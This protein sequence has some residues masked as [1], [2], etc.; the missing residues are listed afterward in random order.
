MIQNKFYESLKKQ[1]MNAV[2]DMNDKRGMLK[3]KAPIIT[4][5]GEY[6][7]SKRVLSDSEIKKNLAMAVPMIVAQNTAKPAAMA[8]TVLYTNNKIKKNKAINNFIREY[9]EEH[10]N[11]KLTDKEIMDLYE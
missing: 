11:T 3:A 8:F 4:F 9:K 5:D 2:V 7:Y 6:D 1:G 10:P